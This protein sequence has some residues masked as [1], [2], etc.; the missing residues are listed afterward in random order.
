VEA[1]IHS[2]GE[3]F[4]DHELRTEFLAKD[5]IIADVAVC[6]VQM[7]PTRKIGK[8]EI[9]IDLQLHKDGHMTLSSS[10]LMR[11]CQLWKSRGLPIGQAKTKATKCIQEALREKRLSDTRWNSVYEFVLGK[12]APSRT[13][14]PTTLLKF[15]ILVDDNDALTATSNPRDGSKEAIPP[16]PV[17]ARSRAAASPIRTIPWADHTYDFG[18]G[19]TYNFSKN[20]YVDRDDEGHCNDCMHIRGV[21]FGDIDRDGQEEALVVVGTNLGGA[22]TILSGYIY[23]LD[24]GSPV[25]R[26]TVEGGDRGEGGIDSM[27]VKDGDVIVRRFAV[28]ASGSTGGACCPSRIEI[29]RWHWDGGKLVKIGASRI[30]RRA[31]KPWHSSRQDAREQGGTRL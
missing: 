1:A 15:T 20:Y 14:Y 5:Q 30:V 12:P 10:R 22:S 16:G 7:F 23:G 6:V 29:E 9:W 8:Y 26:A 27:M 3:F 24:N 11:P 25:L 21:T 19:T 13:H 18:G 4:A 17:K 2:R 28:S 31:P